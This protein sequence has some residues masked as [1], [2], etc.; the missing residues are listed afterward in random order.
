MLAAVVA[1]VA[2]FWRVAVVVRVEAVADLR[3]ATIEFF[4]PPVLPRTPVLVLS[5]VV[6]DAGLRTRVITG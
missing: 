6:G 3:G 1:S 4:L 5:L 2:R